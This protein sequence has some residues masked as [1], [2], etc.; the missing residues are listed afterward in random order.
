MIKQ[1]VAKRLTDKELEAHASNVGEDCKEQY[2]NYRIQ[3]LALLDQATEDGNVSLAGFMF[4]FSA[5]SNEIARRN[6]IK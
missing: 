5:V 1:K 3:I 4:A 2:D 6:G